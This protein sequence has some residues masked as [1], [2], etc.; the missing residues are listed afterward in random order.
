MRERV[1]PGC[2]QQL[3]PLRGDHAGLHHVHQPSAVPDLPVGLHSKYEPG[4]PAVQARYSGLPELQQPNQLP[5]VP[6]RLL[7]Q[8]HRQ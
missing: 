8:Y 3:Y 2:G 5:A 6:D 7:P 4:L 1:L